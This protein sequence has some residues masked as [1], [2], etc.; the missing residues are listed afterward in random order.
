MT[1]DFPPPPEPLSHQQ[2]HLHT[3]TAGEDGS[4]LAEMAKQFGLEKQRQ[5]RKQV[6]D[7]TTRR[8]S[9]FTTRQRVQ[10]YIQDHSI[11][12]ARMRAA[13]SRQRRDLHLQDVGVLTGAAG[14]RS[15]DMPE[16]LEAIEFEEEDLHAQG[17]GGDLTS[18]V[19]GI[20]KGMVGPAI[21]LYVR[22]MS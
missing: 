16:W 13:Y 18:A 9:L 6:R 11:E 7:E 8:R 21:L 15:L 12:A 19:L 2:S 3:Y 20:I 1:H 5:P 14:G 17:V 22:L 4:R 10:H